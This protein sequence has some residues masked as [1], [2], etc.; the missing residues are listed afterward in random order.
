MYASRKHLVYYS[1][2]P[3]DRATLATSVNHFKMCLNRTTLNLLQLVRNGLKKCIATCNY[4]H[5]TP[6][7][8]WKRVFTHHRDRFPNVLMLAEI[9]LVLPQHVVNM[10]FPSWAK[11]NLTGCLGCQLKFSTG[12]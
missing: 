6:K 8:L 12:L 9:L 11:S 4:L 1:Q 10:G 7:A 3:D 2:W 5:L